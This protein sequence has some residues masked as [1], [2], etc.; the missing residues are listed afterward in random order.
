M[1]Y[2][3]EFKPKAIKD[4][5]II[6]DNK[7]SVLILNKIE[8]LKNNLIGDVKKLTNFVPEY[9]LRIGDYRVL[10]EIIDYTIIVYRI[11]HR[12]EVYR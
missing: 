6:K 9:R 12:K 4:L 3:I 1:Q 11:L 5:A 10:F 7:I 2:E 8:L